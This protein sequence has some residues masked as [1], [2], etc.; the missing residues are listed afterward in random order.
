VK[1]QNSQTNLST[2]FSISQAHIFDI[3]HK[4]LCF[5]PIADIGS[6]TNNQKIIYLA[7]LG[8]VFVR[9][10]SIQFNLKS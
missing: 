2:H 10:R 3:L 8:T 7:V 9:K 6:Q 1:L 5:R 4:R